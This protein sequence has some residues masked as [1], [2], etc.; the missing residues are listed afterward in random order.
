MFRL[1]MVLW[2]LGLTIVP[3]LQAAEMAITLNN[4]NIEKTP[5]YSP[6]ERHDKI[7]S[8][9]E[10]NK[11]IATLFVSGKRINYPEGKLLLQQWDK[12]GQLLG[13]H[14]YSEFNFDKI[15]SK[16]LENDTL[17]N[18]K[19][20]KLYQ[21]YQRV[22]RFPFLKEGNSTENRD[23]FRAFLQKNN[24]ANG[25]VTI[26]ASDE[27]I[28]DRLE[29]HL[30][31]NPNAGLAE[32]KKY[33]LNHIWERAK[34]YDSL[35][36]RLL[37]RSPKHVLVIHH[38]L[39]NALFLDDLIKMFQ[40]KGW[41]IINPTTAYQDP[42]YQSLPNIVPAGNSLIWALAKETK[43]YDH[44]LRDPPEDGLYEKEAMDKLGL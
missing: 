20:I 8:A 19:I 25:Y 12:A 17:K 13:N 21:N 6:Q 33:Y 43:K 29:K 5:L 31:M 18:D 44:E 35:A 11:V 42:V 16:Q 34:Y 15:S 24:Y 32:Y 7:L 27:Y 4:P 1:M 10:K 3:K 36:I 2:V 26:D 38:N 30:A 9:L 28:N 41:K 14:S 23:K 22:F 39:L 40:N 37:G